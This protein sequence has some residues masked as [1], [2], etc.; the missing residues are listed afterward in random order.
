[1]RLPA[2][3]DAAVAGTP[4]LHVFALSVDAHAARTR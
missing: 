2:S 1:V 3:S 4:S